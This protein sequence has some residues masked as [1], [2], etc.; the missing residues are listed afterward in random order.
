MSA[1]ILSVADFLQRRERRAQ[2]ALRDFMCGPTP[3]PKRLSLDEIMRPWW[4]PRGG[5]DAA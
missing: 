2:A 1:R 4:T 5:G 3:P